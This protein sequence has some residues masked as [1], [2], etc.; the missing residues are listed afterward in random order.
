MFGQYSMLQPKQLAGDAGF[1]EPEVCDI[2]ES[3]ELEV[4]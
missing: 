2:C 4:E 1:T 3:Y